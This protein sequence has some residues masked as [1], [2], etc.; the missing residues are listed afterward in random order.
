MRSETREDFEEYRSFSIGGAPPHSPPPQRFRTIGRQGVASVPLHALRATSDSRRAVLSGMVAT[1]TLAHARQVEQSD[2]LAYLARGAHHHG[3]RQPVDQPP[4]V[5]GK[6]ASAHFMRS[7][8][9][10]RGVHAR[11]GALS[12]R[13]GPWGDFR[14]GP[15]SLTQRRFAVWKSPLAFTRQRK[16]PAK[17]QSLTRGGLF[18]DTK[19]PYSASRVKSW[20][21]LWVADAKPSATQ[22]HPGGVVLITQPPRWL[23]TDL[24]CSYFGRESTQSQSSKGARAHVMRSGASLRGVQARSGSSSAREEGDGD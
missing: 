2:H 3:P 17:R 19:C 10:P 12:A 23:T 8:A 15:I 11:S 13:G 6:G 4:K 7:G 20:T 24:V 21:Y 5:N 1:A 14:S 16:T 9:A 18:A 22:Y